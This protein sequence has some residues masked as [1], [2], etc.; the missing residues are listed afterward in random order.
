MSLCRTLIGV[1]YPGKILRNRRSTLIRAGIPEDEYM[2]HE[3]KSVAK[4]Q[5]VVGKGAFDAIFSDLVFQGEGSYTLVP[6]SD[7][8]PEVNP[9][10]AA[11]SDLIE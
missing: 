9:A 2:E 8:R 10:D 4:I 1:A 6:E 7:G 11:F 5:K 3:L